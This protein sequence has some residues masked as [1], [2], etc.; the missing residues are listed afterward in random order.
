[1]ESVC[2]MK[3]MKEKERYFNYKC[4]NLDVCPTIDHK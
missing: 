1:M 3:E 4:R 2:P